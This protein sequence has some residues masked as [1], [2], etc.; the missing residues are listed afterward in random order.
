ME[1]ISGLIIIVAVLGLLDLA[2]LRWGVN[3]RGAGKDWSKPSEIEYYEPD[4]F[5]YR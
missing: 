4:G 5:G 2:A 1:L 3:S